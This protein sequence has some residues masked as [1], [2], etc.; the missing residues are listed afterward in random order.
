ML[1]QKSPETAKQLEA[2]SD[3]N[4][5]EVID[6]EIIEEVKR[7]AAIDQTLQAAINE[8]VAAVQAEQSSLQQL[9][10]L[11]DKI[12]VVN[13]ATVQNQTNNISI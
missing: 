12:G 1:R 5:E 3:R 4:H 6:A 11:A 8:T 9:T 10:K 2:A 13:L 7:V